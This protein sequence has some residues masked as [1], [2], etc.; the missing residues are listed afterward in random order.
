MKVWHR[1]W[2]IVHPIIL[3][4]MLAGSLTRSGAV[5]MIFLPWRQRPDE[6]RRPLQASVVIRGRGRPRL[7]DEIR[8]LFGELALRA[9]TLN[10]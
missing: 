1:I 7:F 10:P 4:A 6:R 5:A 3:L 2:P 9:A 8:R